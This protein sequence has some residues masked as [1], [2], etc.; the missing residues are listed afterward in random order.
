MEK[1]NRFKK[2]K[3]QEKR[4]QGGNKGEKEEKIPRS[5]TKEN[6]T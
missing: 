6:D 5:Q 3:S 1:N 2:K 4:W